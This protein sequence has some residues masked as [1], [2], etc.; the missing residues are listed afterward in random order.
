MA[1]F[2]YKAGLHN[3]GSYQVSGKPFA[4]GSITCRDDGLPMVVVRFPSVTS[5]IVIANNDIEN[6]P[7]HG[8]HLRVG[9]SENGVDGHGL[10]GNAYLEISGGVTTPRLDLKVSELWLSGSTNCSV[11]AGLTFISPDAI[12]NSAISPNGTNWSGAAGV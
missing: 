10:N 4:T 7:L 8:P 9:F 11:V 6:V 1:N 12:N 5:W 2:Q 3:V